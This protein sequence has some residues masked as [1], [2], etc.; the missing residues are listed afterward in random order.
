MISPRTQ[1]QLRNHFLVEKELA[2]RLRT[3]SPEERPALYETLYDELFRRVPDTPALRDEKL[4]RNRE[5][6]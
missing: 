2:A 1:E 6:R 3:A 4:R 5:R